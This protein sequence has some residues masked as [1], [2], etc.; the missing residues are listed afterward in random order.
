M[1]KMRGAQNMYPVLS[2][3]GKTIMIRV[4]I[5][6]QKRGG[7]KLIVAPDGTDG[8]AQYRQDK[9]VTLFKALARAHRWKKMLDTGEVVSIKELAETEKI[10]D[11]YLARVLRLTLLA[12]DIVE[13]V[14]N[15][16]HP[17]GLSLLELMRGFPMEWSLQ[18]EKFGF[19]VET[20]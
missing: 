12:P 7:R 5:K 16:Q 17:K 8:L 11:S 4:P 9:D 2:Q 19:A 6:F 1:T 10:N 14:L 20:A 15:G 3:D 13:A 18:R